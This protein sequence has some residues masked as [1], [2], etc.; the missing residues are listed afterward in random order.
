MTEI[1][2]G[3]RD[4][5]HKV[6]E[7]AFLCRTKQASRDNNYCNIF[8][9]VKMNNHLVFISWLLY[10]TS[11][12]YFHELAPGT[13]NLTG[14]WVSGN[15]SEQSSYYIK[16]FIIDIHN[17][18]CTNDKMSVSKVTERFIQAAQTQITHDQSFIEY[19]QKMGHQNCQLLQSSF[20]ESPDQLVGLVPDQY[21]QPVCQHMRVI[22]LKV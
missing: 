3:S 20:E 10:N 16:F 1:K 7:L 19:A 13:V 17:M 8:I 15:D 2:Q 21:V 18:E 22:P 5:H 11:F 4:T 9:V 12:V 6:S 14:D